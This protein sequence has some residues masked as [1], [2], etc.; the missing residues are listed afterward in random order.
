MYT[1]HHWWLGLT[2]E[3][4]EGHWKW[5]DNGEQAQ[6]LGKCLRFIN[7]TLTYYDV[8]HVVSRLVCLI[9][10]FVKSKR[11]RFYVKL[12]YISQKRKTNC[13]CKR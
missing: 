3:E 12:N 1:D 4:I 10:C 2:D 5:F 11:L 7:L 8:E 13:T 9:V 6:F